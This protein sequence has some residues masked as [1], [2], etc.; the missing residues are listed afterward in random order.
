MSAAASIVKLYYFL[1]FSQKRDSKKNLNHNNS[2]G[3]NSSLIPLTNGTRNHMRCLS[4]SIKLAFVRIFLC[5][6]RNFSTMKRPSG[7]KGE[8]S[9]CSKKVILILSFFHR[10][11]NNTRHITHFATSH[12][13]TTIFAHKNDISGYLRHILPFSVGDLFLLSITMHVNC[14]FLYQWG[15][16]WRHVWISSKLLGS[17]RSKQHLWGGRR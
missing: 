16:L 8:G 17:R 6:L 10:W 4:P 9:I 1:L 12:R 13:G 2:K 5:I 15:S 3:R 11:A 7:R 14:P